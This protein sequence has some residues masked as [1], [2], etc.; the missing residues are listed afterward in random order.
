MK[1]ILAACNA[2]TSAALPQLQEELR[3]PVV[4]VI[5]P[6]AHAAVQ[7]TRNRRVGLMATQAT[8]EAGR[9]ARARAHARRRARSS[10]PWPA[11]A[12]CR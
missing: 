2:A 5:T 8:V 7:A 10:S 11:R 6:E 4:G 1:L 12:W 9:Y 3:V